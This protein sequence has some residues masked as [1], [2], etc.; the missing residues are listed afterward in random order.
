MCQRSALFHSVLEQFPFSCKCRSFT[1]VT[2]SWRTPFPI[3]DAWELPVSWRGTCLCGEIIWC[4]LYQESCKTPLFCNSFD[5]AYARTSV[6]I[7]MQCV[8]LVGVQISSFLSMFGTTTDTAHRIETT[9][10]SCLENVS[11]NDIHHLFTRLLPR[12]QHCD[13]ILPVLILL[14]TVGY[15]LCA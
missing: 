6:W 10:A 12:I 11:Q 3:E 13:L 5:F 8:T 15:L 7:R 14:W 9:G 2:Q 4:P 1:Y